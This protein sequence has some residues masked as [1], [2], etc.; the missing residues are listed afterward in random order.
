M[1]AATLAPIKALRRGM[2]A[3]AWPEL[4]SGLISMKPAEFVLSEFGMLCSPGPGSKTT[5]CFLQETDP[6]RARQVRDAAPSRRMHAQ[7]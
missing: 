2:E 6:V 7:L 5:S 4:A 1:E 3:W